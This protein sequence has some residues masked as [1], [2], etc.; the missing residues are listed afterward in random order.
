VSSLTGGKTPTP[1][2]TATTG[3]PGGVTSG[4]EC[5]PCNVVPHPG[6][7]GGFGGPGPDSG[8][9]HQIGAG[10]HEPSAGP[11]PTGTTPQPATSTSTQK[12]VDLASNK[13]P[14][15]Q[16]PAVLAILAIIALAL[17][18]GTYARLY[19]LRRNPA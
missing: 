14:A 2:D 13:A 17:V 10:L 12:R 15:A 1:T 16:V 9:I 4:T 8:G 6:L 7:G 19:L 11:V 3:S 5:V 18:G